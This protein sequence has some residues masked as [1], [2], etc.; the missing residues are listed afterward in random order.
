MSVYTVHL[1]SDD[2]QE[3]AFVREGFSWGAFLVAPLWL[4]RYRLWLAFLLWCAAIVLVFLGPLQLSP[5]AQEAAV[6][7]IA[8]LCGLEGRQWRRQKLLRQGK[9]VSDIVAGEE[10]DDAE[11]R[12]FQ[13]WQEIPPSAP[14]AVPR[15]IPAGQGAAAETAFG[16]FPEPENRL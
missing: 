11:V 12:F 1:Q 9:P 15:A 3:A 7:L 10:L 14:A 6:L 16:H 8:L 2:A 4:L 5:V 13:R